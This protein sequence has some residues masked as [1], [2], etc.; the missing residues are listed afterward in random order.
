M[1]GQPV[2]PESKARNEVVVFGT[3]ALVGHRFVLVAEQGSDL[4]GISGK[5][6]LDLNHFG[7]DTPSLEA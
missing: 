3:K 4:G 1:T 7:N 6:G 2:L 5:E